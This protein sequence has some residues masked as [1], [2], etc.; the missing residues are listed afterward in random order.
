MFSVECCFQW[1]MEQQQCYFDCKSQIVDIRNI[2]GENQMYTN[3][4]ISFLCYASLFFVFFPTALEVRWE[5]P[6]AW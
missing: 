4:V 3:Q 1:E 5:A 6:Q 2:K